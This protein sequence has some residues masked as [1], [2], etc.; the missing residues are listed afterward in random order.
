MPSIHP[1]D[2][3]LAKPWKVVAM[4]SGHGEKQHSL[5]VGREA[6]KGET[7][8]NWLEAAYYDSLTAQL[9]AW[10]SP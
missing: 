1:E 7:L 3:E 9:E 2:F 5:L 10:N 8:H 4:A 6:S